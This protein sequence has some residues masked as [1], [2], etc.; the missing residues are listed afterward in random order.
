MEFIRE[1]DGRFGIGFFMVF[2]Q[3]ILD[4]NNLF[5]LL[6]LSTFIHNIPVEWVESTLRLSSSA[7]IHRR[8]LPA[9]QVF[10]LVLG[11]AIF[12]DVLIHAAAR[13]LNICDK[14]LTSYDLLTRIGLTEARKHLGADPVEW[15][16]HQTGQH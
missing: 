2:Q 6:N 10:W 12:R 4:L 9:D 16:F 11:M 8:C 5:N 13:R 14:W 3:D 15:L 1:S 7:T